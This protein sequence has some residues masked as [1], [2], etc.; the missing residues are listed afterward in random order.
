MILDAW[1]KNIPYILKKGK[2]PLDDCR[3]YFIHENLDVFQRVA[4][5]ESGEFIREKKPLYQIIS[6]NTDQED[7]FMFDFSDSDTIC[8]NY[9][10]VLNPYSVKKGDV[11]FIN[12][13]QFLIKDDPYF[14]LWKESMERGTFG[15]KTI[16]IEIRSEIKKITLGGNFFD[17]HKSDY[18]FPKSYLDRAFSTN[19]K[20]L[21]NNNSKKNPPERRYKPFLTHMVPEFPRRKWNKKVSP[22]PPN[23]HWGQFKLLISE[24]ELLNNC[25]NSKTE[26]IVVYA[27]A[28]HGIHIPLLSRMF[29]ELLFILYDPG[30]F[31][32]KPS[33]NIII[34]NEF[35]TNQEAALYRGRDVIFI[36]DI[37]LSA[38][39]D[40]EFEDNVDKNNRM[41]E[42]WVNIIKPYR[43]LLKTR[44]PF[45][46]KDN[47]YE[48]FAGTFYFQ[49]FPP[50]VSAETRMVPHTLNKEKKVYDT[51]VYEEQMFY[52]NTNY[53]NHSFLDLDP[54]FG[55]NYDVYK[56][57]VV[58]KKYYKKNFNFKDENILRKNI[59]GFLLY[60]DTFMNKKIFEEL[61]GIEQNSEKKSKNPKRNKNRSKGRNKKGRS[62]K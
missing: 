62:K 16:D 14:T 58:L 47:K 38:D 1:C 52:F 20:Q 37:R 60:S 61:F 54:V 19:W 53:R 46:A 33:P 51:I 42:D 55:I 40:K 17:Q 36:S 6:A 41:H 3:Y 56:T 43:S 45:D 13:D 31:K 8:N 23:Q 22:N 26:G 49:V 21:E 28:A 27:G 50:Y 59:L 29:N 9:F 10:K 24:I 39:D 34:R 18:L 57:F 12:G 4:S 5:E 35:F 32:I 2:S 15:K 44:F 48:F 30:H 25:C 11:F 7:I